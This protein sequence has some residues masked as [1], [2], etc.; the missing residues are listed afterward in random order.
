[1]WLV[2]LIGLFLLAGLYECYFG[3]ESGKGRY[4]PDLYDDDDDDIPYDHHAGT[5]YSMGDG[6]RYYEGGSS[7]SSMGDVTHYSGGGRS[8]RSGNITYY[9]DRNDRPIGRSVRSGNVTTY[10]NNANREVG[11]TIDNGNGYYDHFGNTFTDI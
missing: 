9:F 4:D 11:R 2:G 3:E 10:L 5:S 1:M 6:I 7:G 8:V